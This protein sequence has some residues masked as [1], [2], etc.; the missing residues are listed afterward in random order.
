MI[1]VEGKAGRGKRVEGKAKK[2]RGWTTISDSQLHAR[3][4]P[5]R[6]T[7]TRLVSGQ[8]AAD[9]SRAG[10]KGRQRNRSAPE[11][12]RSGLI[13]IHLASKSERVTHAPLFLGHALCLLT[14][15]FE[16]TCHRWIAG[17]SATL[18]FSEVEGGEGRA[19]TSLEAERARRK[20][21]RTEDFIIAAAR[22]KEE[23]RGRRRGGL[24]AVKVSKGKGR[25]VSACLC[26][27][28]F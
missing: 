23:R 21:E 17:W 18:L 25:F 8:R 24:W 6:L 11:T 12:R 9:L 26:L 14:M 28:S 4:R 16:V 7:T 13:A 20:N 22:K 1:A 10:R 3:H 2:G 19:V 5:A 15:S 27:W